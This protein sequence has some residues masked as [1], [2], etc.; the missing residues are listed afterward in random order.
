MPRPPE[1]NSKLAPF[2]GRALVMDGTTLM[3]GDVAELVDLPFG[4]HRV[5]CTGSRGE[6]GGRTRPTV[7]L[8]DGE[9]LPAA[10]ARVAVGGCGGDPQG[11]GELIPPEWNHVE[12]YEPGATKLLHFAD[13]ATQPWRNDRHPLDEVWMAWYREAMEA[14]AVP[15]HEVES[16][17]DAGHVKASLG[18][19]SVLCWM[20]WTEPSAKT[21]LAPDVCP[22]LYARRCSSP[23][24][25]STLPAGG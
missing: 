12:H 1:L 16:L 11:I 2:R 23:V 20:K 13:V 18:S 25:M 21:K 3:F 10:A 15:P 17:V 19:A 22:L 6:G 14:G 24:V 8:V 9:H 5:L 7:L 4:P